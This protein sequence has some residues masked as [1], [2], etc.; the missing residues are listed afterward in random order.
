MEGFS[1]RGVVG[2]G[3]APGWRAGWDGSKADPKVVVT[4]LWRWLGTEVMLVAERQA[5]PR[6]HNVT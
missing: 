3:G 5:G 2:P 4:R 1:Q 6:W